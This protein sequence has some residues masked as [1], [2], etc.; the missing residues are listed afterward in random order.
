MKCFKVHP[1]SR[2]YLAV[3]GVLCA[4]CAVG[5]SQELRPQ[6]V[7]EL[8]SREFP[9]FVAYAD[10]HMWNFP[11]HTG[12]EDIVQEA[13]RRTLKALEK[14]TKISDLPRWIR[15][16]IDHVIIDMKRLQGTWREVLVDS[17]RSI[18]SPSAPVEKQVIA[19]MELNDLRSHLGQEGYG[20]VEAHASGQSVKQIA[21]EQRLAQ[22]IVQRRLI[23][24][25]RLA[26]KFWQSK[27]GTAVLVLVGTAIVTE[28]ILEVE[29]HASISPPSETRHNGPWPKLGQY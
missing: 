3:L 15:R 4:L 5:Y 10:H 20:I 17:V 19:R 28:I 23:T 1:L 29:A 21:A 6:A 27:S 25:G 26:K 22:H 11:A 8:Y 24:A 7:A 9:R 16:T 2:L 18:P 13:F 14:G 12:A